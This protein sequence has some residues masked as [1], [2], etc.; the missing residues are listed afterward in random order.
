MRPTTHWLLLSI[1]RPRVVVALPSAVSQIEPNY[2][3]LAVE[4]TQITMLPGF[5]YVA[6]C[7]LWRLGG[8]GGTR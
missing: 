3:E 5:R 7:V 8:Q 1:T 2:G 6:R 4:A